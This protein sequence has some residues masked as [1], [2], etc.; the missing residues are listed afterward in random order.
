ML[1]CICKSDKK[2]DKYQKDFDE[3]YNEFKKLCN[4]YLNNSLED[5]KDKYRKLNKK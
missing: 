4:F 3:K 1:N 5:S 2:K